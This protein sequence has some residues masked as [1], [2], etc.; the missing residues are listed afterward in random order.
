MKAIILNEPGEPDNLQL[1]E[2]EKPTLKPN[3]VLIKAKALSINPVDIKTRKGKAQYGQLRTE[4]PVILGWDISGE[5]VEVGNEVK[6]FKV[7]DAVFGMVNFPGHGKAYAEYVAAPEI[8]LAL[9][10][11]SISHQEAAAATLAALT[12]WQV[13]VQQAKIKPGQRV[14]IQAAAGGVG[15]FAVQIAKHIGA[16]VIGVASGNN[17]DFLKELGVNQ[18]I[19]Y[20]QEQFEEA[21]P[22]VD[23]VLDS[24]GGDMVSRYFKILKNEAQLIS[25]V[26]GVNE[27]M[28]KR[29][30]ALHIKAA[31]YL[32]HSSGDDMQ[33]LAELLATGVLKAHVSQEFSFENIADAHRQ[34]ETGKTRGKVVINLD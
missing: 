22:V 3:E 28:K 5:V 24:L 19:D 2:I 7:G 23:F 17:A 33:K 16:Y 6:K 14:F 34:I 12:A 4:P 32:V 30:D 15:H 21:L 13:L 27:E 18:H 8:H 31:N 20:T 10:P 29:A 9:K 11:E 25:I 1:Q 26:G